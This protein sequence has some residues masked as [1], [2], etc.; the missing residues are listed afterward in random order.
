[1]PLPFTS[2]EVPVQ[3]S[4][5]SPGH[6]PLESGAFSFA[7]VEQSSTVTDVKTHPIPLRLDPQLTALLQEGVRRTPHKQAAL[8]RLTLRR[9]LRSVI[10]AEALPPPSASLTNVAPWPEGTLSRAFQVTAAED[11]ALED[12]GAAAQSTPRLDD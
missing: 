11:R 8:V 1:V 3:T 2:A 12:A 10:D 5:G 4:I 7:P 9:H 6:E